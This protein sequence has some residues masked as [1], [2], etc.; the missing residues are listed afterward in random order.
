MMLRPRVLATGLLLAVPAALV[1]TWSVSRTRDRDQAIALERVVQSQV[2]D[3][4]RERCESDPNWFFTGP[5]IGRP[6]K[7]TIIDPDNPPRPR[8][9]QQPFE[10]FA[11]DD[12]FLGS[13][14]AAPR[15]PADL[16]NTLRTLAPAASGTYTS[17]QGT[18]VQIAVA[19]GWIDGPCAYFL[20][21][22][23]PPPDHRSALIWLALATFGLT[24]LVALVTSAQTVWRVRRVARDAGASARGEFTP[25]APDSIKDELGAVT[26]AFNDLIT[27]LQQRRARI[28]DVDAALRRFVDTTDEQIARPLARIERTLGDVALGR[29]ADVSDAARRAAIEAHDLTA[30]V[31]NLT[32]AARLRMSAPALTT[33]EVDLTGVVARVVA[34]H[35]AFAASAGITVETQAPGAPVTVLADELLIERAISNLVDNAIRYNRP[36]GSVTIS[37]APAGDGQPVRVWVTDTGP[38]VSDE[39]F[40]GLTAVRRFR[41][42]EHRTRRPGAPGLGLAVTRE[43]ADRFGMVLELRRPGAGG[44][45]AEVRVRG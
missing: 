24:A 35:R 29:T 10:L 6:R 28:E 16:R 41:G 17:A 38:G 44:F 45:E 27:E 13:S 12:Q 21:R 11:Y 19:T 2:N 5:L 42:D 43:V 20:A 36:N 30:R 8:Y 7:D 33:T 14:A 23:Q 26:F 39:E 40:R 22:L 37:L 31:E 9:T 25:I 3:Q 18:G 34:R 4:V 15:F 32:A 1:V